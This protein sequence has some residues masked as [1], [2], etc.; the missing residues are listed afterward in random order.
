MGGWDGLP[1]QQQRQLRV[2]PKP[3]PLFAQCLAEP[4]VPPAAWMC[5]APCPSVPNW[6][7]HTFTS[8]GQNK[9]VGDIHRSLEKARTCE[10]L[11]KVLRISSE[12]YCRLTE[13]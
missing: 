5:Q 9:L 2:F 1:L 12:V 8:T 11:L 10:S 3:Q 6:A 4:H 7:V 13:D